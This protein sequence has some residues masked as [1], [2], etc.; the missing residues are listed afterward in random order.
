MHILYK[1]RV[2]A[3]ITNKYIT[4]VILKKYFE[5]SFLRKENWKQCGLNRNM[6]H[7]GA[8]GANA[9]TSS[10]AYQCLNGLI[11]LRADA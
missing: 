3:H 7:V 11:T 1:F 2:Y 10:A 6:T 9:W 8:H 5:A 4:I